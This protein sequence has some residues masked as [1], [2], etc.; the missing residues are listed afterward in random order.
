MRELTIPSEH[1]D[2][3]K[4]YVS[5][6]SELKHQIWEQLSRVPI[7]LQPSDIVDFAA[8]NIANLPK[9]R[10]SDIFQIYFNLVRAKESLNIEM[11]EFIDIL[12]HSLKQIGINPTDE[13]VIDF[14]KLLSS[15]D[16][17]LI[18]AKVI[19]SMTE[20]QKTFA[21]AK[22]YQ[23]IRP[24]FDDDG[25][26]LGSIVIHNLKLLYKEDDSIKEFYLSLDNNDLDD[27]VS[28]LREA[29]DKLKLIKSHFEEKSKFIEIK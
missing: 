4:F 23:D 27:M 12:R 24:T 11:G 3:F 28:L 2:K 26:L 10:I 15:S 29:Q 17:A 16:S 9:E 8:R 21:S 14:E 18:T 22:I 19:N 6:S 1:Y 20:N 25:N 7:G 13:I 5:L